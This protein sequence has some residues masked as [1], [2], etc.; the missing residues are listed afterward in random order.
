MNGDIFGIH[1]GLILLRFSS[2]FN[3]WVCMCAFENSTFENE[4]HT[5]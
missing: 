5:C 2:V 3:M 4:E 1:D